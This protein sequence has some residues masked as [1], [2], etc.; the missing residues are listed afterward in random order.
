[1]IR[2]FVVAQDAASA[3][4]AVVVMEDVD[5]FEAAQQELEISEAYCAASCAAL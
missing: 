2:T 5:I 3:C 1:M 4:A